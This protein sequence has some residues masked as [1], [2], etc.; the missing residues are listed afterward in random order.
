MSKSVVL[1]TQKSCS[2]DEALRLYDM[3]LKQLDKLKIEVE[4]TSIDL[5]NAININVRKTASDLDGYDYLFASIFGILGAVLSTSKSIEDF[6][7]QIHRDA[8]EKSPKT[9]IGKVLN[10]KGDIIDQVD[11][12]FINRN[13]QM[14]D[15]KFH[16]LLWGHD[17]LSFGGDNPF[18]LLIQQN[19]LLKGV[20]QVFRHLIADTFSI[21]GLPIPGHSFLDKQS[22]GKTTNLLKEMSMKLADNNRGKAGEYF[23][24]MFTIRAQDIAGQGFVWATSK[25]YFY[26]RGIDDIARMRQY[27]IISYAVNFFAH[28]GVGAIRQGGVPYISWPALAALVKETAGLFIDSYKE[29]RQ[30]EKITDNLVSENIKL[31]KQVFSTGADLKSYDDSNGYIKELKKQDKIFEDLVSF[32]EE[33]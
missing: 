31:E 33:G 18:Y 14:A 21:Q 5:E 20:V 3:S 28:A 11:G 10:H 9:F 2:R 29:I 22:G 7:N 25:A 26:A 8:S 19:R 30:L 1:Y 27:K 15:I 23:S 17:P 6:C 24:H 16:R 4:K 13:G 32:F 12:S